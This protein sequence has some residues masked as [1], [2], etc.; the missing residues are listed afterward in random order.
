MEVVKKG[1]YWRIQNTRGPVPNE[2]SGDYTSEGKAK[3]VLENFQAKV[4]SRAVNTAELKRERIKR[5]A[6][7]YSATASGI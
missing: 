4:R 2:L 7:S 1:L 3:Q 6:T 5:A